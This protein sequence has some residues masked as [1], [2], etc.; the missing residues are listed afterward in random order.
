MANMIPPHKRDFATTRW[1]LVLN[2]GQRSGQSANNALEEL[3]KRYWYPL[4]SF[5]RRRVRDVDEAQDLTQEFFSFLL[6]KGV[7]ARAVPDRGRFRS[8]LL[9]SLKNFLANQWD[10]VNARKRGGGRRRL[11]L[12]FETGESRL[13]L[14]PAHNLSPERLYERQWA[15]TLLQLV[16]TKLEAEYTVASKT[17]QFE[18]LKSVLTGGHQ[19]LAYSDFASQLGISEAATR[20][21]A[22]RLRKR[23]REL[24]RNEVAHTVADSAAVDEEINSLFAAL[25]S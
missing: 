2:A 1:S 10:R 8:F 6:E 3:C 18:V 5:V 24:L 22:H 17:R 7:L 9:A 12:D 21:A 4:Y 14:E 15:M 11:A 25:A 16:V 23:Y 13:S 19:V 20:Q